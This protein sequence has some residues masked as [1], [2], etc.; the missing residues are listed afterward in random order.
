MHEASQRCVPVFCGVNH[1]V[2]RCQQICLDTCLCLDFESSIFVPRDFATCCE[3]FSRRLYAE[4]FRCMETVAITRTHKKNGGYQY[5][6]LL[7]QACKLSKN[8]KKWHPGKPHTLITRSFLMG[9]FSSLS[10]STGAEPRNRSYLE[11]FGSIPL[12]CCHFKA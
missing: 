10:R 2:C 11:P 1:S 12:C 3:P 4:F 8:H 9:T 6:C 7:L 5:I